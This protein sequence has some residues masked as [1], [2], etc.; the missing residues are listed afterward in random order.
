MSLLA[1]RVEEQIPEAKYAQKFF[2]FKI[3]KLLLKLKDEDGN[4]VKFNESQWGMVNG[5]ESHRFWVHIAG[6]RTG[7]SYAAAVLALT[8]LLEPNT[9][10]AVVAPNFSLSTVIWDYLVRLI[11]ELGLETEKQST[12]DRLIILKN[13]SEVRLLSVENRV[14]LIGR[15][16]HF[17]IV[18][19]AAVIDNDIYFNQD[20][21]PTLST[22]K[23]T[24]CLF[25]ST[26]RGKHNYLYDYFLRGQ[27]E[28]GNEFPDWGSDVFTWRANPRLQ[29]SEVMEAKK[30]MTKTLF[31]QEYEC[32]WHSFENMVYSVPEESIIENLNNE[33]QGRK[34][35]YIAGLD[36]GFRDATAFIVVATD[37]E[38]YY[39][40]DEYVVNETVTSEMARN[41]TELQQK[42]DI[43]NIYID[44]QAQQTKADLANDYDI[45]CDN[46]IKAVEDGIGH[47]QNLLEKRKIQIDRS[48]CPNT[49]SS[50]E[51]YK[52]SKSTIKPTPVHDKNSHCSDAVRYCI[53]SHQKTQVNIFNA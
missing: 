14:S 20:I 37:Y 10:V 3:E 7:K 18:D 27:P 24:R 40:V 13:W 16:Y 9:K 41:I 12:K 2:K 15:G 49:L 42:Y 39:I 6:R 48:F 11:R 17:V 28:K 32:N 35:E 38:N 34:L 1:Q 5:L 23:N 29:E 21:R 44:S 52:W 30:A 25:I 36:M 43:Q 8:K 45:Y 50:L 53:Y 31:A 19:E 33:I 22:Y 51:Q 4:P 47:I 46:A 26:P